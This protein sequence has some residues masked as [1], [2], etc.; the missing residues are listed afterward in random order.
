MARMNVTVIGISDRVNGVNQKTGK[1]YDFRKVAFSFRNQYGSNDVSVNVVSGDVLD[2]FEVQP[3]NT[4]KAA[5]T[6]VK[7][8]YYIELIDQIF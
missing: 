7:G 1:K 5:V 4:F 3:G 2:E 6:Q 8:S